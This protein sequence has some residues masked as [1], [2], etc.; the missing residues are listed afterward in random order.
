MLDT[1][2]YDPN[3][4][5]V[6][7]EDALQTP[8][9][10]SMADEERDRVKAT[11]MKDY[12]ESKESLPT[13]SEDPVSYS[14][15]GGVLEPLVLVAKQLHFPLPEKIP[16]GTINALSL[17][18]RVIPI[19]ENNQEVLLVFNRS[20]IPFCYLFSSFLT[21]C[22]TRSFSQQDDL[23]RLDLSDRDPTRGELRALQDIIGDSI[24]HTEYS[25]D[26]DG[27]LDSILSDRIAP[28]PKPHLAFPCRNRL[29]IT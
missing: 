18:A 1:F 22:I 16:Y 28:R 4:V 19:D 5:N 20:L 23:I 13:D 2:R 14:I 9:F 26:K 10:L 12:G 25:Y 3:A 7:E 11:F 6:S 27:E 17:N 8:S 24:R 21:S 29:L 15:L